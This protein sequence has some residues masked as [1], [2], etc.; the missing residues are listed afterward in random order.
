MI[1]DQSTRQFLALADRPFPPPDKPDSDKWSPMQDSV[2]FG[3]TV[4]DTYAAI[5]DVDALIR[6]SGLEPALV[7]LVAMRA[8]QINGCAFCLD[9]HAKA[10][11]QMPRAA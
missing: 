4:P 11:R 5:R 3:R 6:R 1:M 7:E 10:A 8:S 9:M 2:S